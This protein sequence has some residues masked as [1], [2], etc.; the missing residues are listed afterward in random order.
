MTS[1]D[2]RANGGEGPGDRMAW[3]GAAL[4]KEL[5]A[6]FFSP[7]AL[8]LAAVYLYLAGYLFRFHL[9]FYHSLSI[10]ALE[11]GMGGSGPGLSDGLVGPFFM[12]LG[13]LGVLLQPL[14]AARLTARRSKESPL[15]WSLRER[16]QQVVVASVRFLM[17][18]VYALVLL[19]PT[20]A[21][22]LYLH[23]VAGAG[24]GRIA[25][26]YAGLLLLGGA[27]SAVTAFFSGRCARPIAAAG[28]TSGTLLLFWVLSWGG[29]LPLWA[30]SIREAFSIQERLGAFAAGAF[31]LGDVLYFVA[32]AL[33]FLLAAGVHRSGVGRAE[34]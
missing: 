3:V 2:R 8:L 19:V 30:R 6:F 29:V 5:A 18:F 10:Q 13:L 31:G 26:G 9:A 17:V 16:P 24:G 15:E 25:G 7:A 20:V 4:R 11:E 33:L 34:G 27:S 28:F 12:T 1:P 32:W 21:A 23:R 22:F 14:L